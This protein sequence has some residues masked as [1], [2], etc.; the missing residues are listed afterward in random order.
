MAVYVAVA[1]FQ[2]RWSNTIDSAIRKSLSSYKAGNFKD[3]NSSSSLPV[4]LYLL[5]RQLNEMMEKWVLNEDT[6]YLGTYRAFSKNGSWIWAK[7]I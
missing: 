4:K 7:Y 3:C 5:N 2:W 6:T 1:P